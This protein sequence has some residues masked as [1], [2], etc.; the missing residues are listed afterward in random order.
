MRVSKKRAGSRR[1]T[2]KVFRKKAVKTNL[3][4]FGPL[5]LAFAIF[6]LINS[7]MFIVTSIYP[8]VV[9]SLSLAPDRPWGIFTSSFIHAS[10]E[11]IFNNMEGFT[12]ASVL[13]VLVNLKSSPESRRRSSRFFFGLIFIAGFLADSIE[14]SVWQLR[15]LQNVSSLG[16]SGMVYAALGVVLASA[17]YNIPKNLAGI[18]DIL[19]ARK[20]SDRNIRRLIA[21]SF[22]IVAFLILLFESVGDPET[23]FSAAP[24]IDVFAHVLGFFI[25]YFFTAMISVWWMLTEHKIR[26]S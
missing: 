1:R 22:A 19:T 15:G 12:F 23:F 9:D 14:F 6:V 18:R 8:S 25:G 26:R 4:G 20:K 16:S 10:P 11:H 24:G 13:F 3:A 17:L 5:V 21:P 2:R 7:L